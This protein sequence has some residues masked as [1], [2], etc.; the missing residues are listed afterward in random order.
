MWHWMQLLSGLSFSRRR[1]ALTVQ[2]SGSWQPGRPRCSGVRRPRGARLGVRVVTSNA[3]EGVRRQVTAAQVHLFDVADDRHRL[4]RRVKLVGLDEILQRQAGAE[5]GQLP[6][7]GPGHGRRA[8]VA[9]LAD[10]LGQ[11]ARQAGRVDDGEVG[12]RRRASRPSWRCD[13]QRAGAVAALAADR[14]LD[15][16]H[17]LQAPLD[18]FGPPRVAEQAVLR[19][20]RAGTPAGSGVVVARRHA[21]RL[22]GGVPRHRRLDQEAV[23]L[24]QVRQRMASRTDD[25]VGAGIPK[26][27]P[28]AGRP[29]RSNSRCQRPPSLRTHLVAAS[30]TPGDRTRRR[31]ARGQG[32]RRPS[33]GPCRC[34]RN[35]AWASSW[36]ARH[37]SLP[38]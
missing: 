16:V 10:R 29:P 19:R 36:Q 35:E 24:G 32:P 3:G 4:V 8:Q 28:P 7:R 1:S 20:R 13:V 31:P 22:P 9:L 27:R 14:L 21:P 15:D 18:R 12:R 11:V 26:G 33:S 2:R 5:V 37:A 30:S 6:S 34:A 23:R 38:T 17:P 25:V